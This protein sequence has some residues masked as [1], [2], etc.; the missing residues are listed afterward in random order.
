MQ[1]GFFQT[2]DKSLPSVKKNFE[3]KYSVLSTSTTHYSYELFFHKPQHILKLCSFIA[4]QQKWAHQN[5]HT[6][7]YNF[8]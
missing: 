5:R 6:V 4:L 1:Q 8:R 2:L 3:I 7:E